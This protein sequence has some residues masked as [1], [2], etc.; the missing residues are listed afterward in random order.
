M[1]SSDLIATK[2]NWSALLTTN[3]TLRTLINDRI[4]VANVQAKY[5]TKA[6]AAS[7]SY[8]KLLLANTN[9]YIAD[10]AA[11]VAAPPS[12]EAIDYGFITSSVDLDTRRDYGTL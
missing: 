1:C 5:A 2:A 7:N 4:Q 10:V 6:Y 8:V 9:A 11:T 12:S 3:T